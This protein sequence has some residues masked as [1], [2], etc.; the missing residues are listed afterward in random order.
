M[1]PEISPFAQQLQPPGN[2]AGAFG[3]AFGDAAAAAAAP[4]APLHPPSGNSGGSDEMLESMKQMLSGQP[5]DGPEVEA[6][7]EVIPNNL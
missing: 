2:L 4:A 1:Q 5:D 6:E 7:E 3:L